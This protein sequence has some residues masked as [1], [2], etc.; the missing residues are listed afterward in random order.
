MPAGVKPRQRFGHFWKHTYFIRNMHILRYV[1]GL[2]GVG[3][4]N[5]HV[6]LR[7]M[8]ILRYVTGLGWGGAC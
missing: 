6:N 7:H 5:V 2:G 8:H 4:V 1:T 3:H